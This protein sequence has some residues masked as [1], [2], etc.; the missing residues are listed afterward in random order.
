MISVIVPYY[1]TEE[2][3]FDNCVRSILYNAE[4]DIELII[5]DDGSDVKYHHICDK[6]L[7]DLRVKVYHLLHKGVSFA[8]NFGINASNG[9]WLMFVDSDD[10]IENDW[11][12]QLAKFIKG[13]ND[14]VICF[15]GF[16]DV[17]G[18]LSKNNFFIKENIDYGQD[19]DLKIRIMES[20]LSVGVLPKEN[21]SYYSLGSPCSK[22]YKTDFLNDNILRFDVEVTFA[23][24]TLFALNVFF[25]AAHIVYYDAYLYHYVL[26]EKSSTKKY[27]PGL[28]K[29]IDMFFDKV[30]QFMNKNCLVI[31]LSNGY[32]IRA[33]VELV[34][35]MD[36][37]FFHEQNCAL[38]GIDFCKFDKF[39]N[40][41]P[42]KTA[43]SRMLFNDHNFRKKIFIILIKFRM[44]RVILCIKKMLALLR[45]F[46][47]A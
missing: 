25:K 40:K 2:S 15:S 47:F 39:V 6:Y 13:R 41:E 28:A 5:V 44:Y 35:A 9:E 23:E 8:R 10:T 42:Y 18:I 24:D 21:L 4:A 16:K 1:Q 33:F 20:A 19:L 34:H 14:E 32:Y 12:T 26:N 30:Y 36:N 45:H 17:N 46:K 11:Y 31:G 3:L 38:K 7:K 22:L 29:E 43:L 37:E 27:R